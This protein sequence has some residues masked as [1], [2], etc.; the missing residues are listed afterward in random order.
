MPQVEVNQ[1]CRD[2]APPLAAGEPGALVAQQL[3]RALPACGQCDEAEAE[4]TE[5]ESP[6]AVAIERRE[7]GAH[8]H[9]SR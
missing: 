8:V 9:G 3:T 6:A 2:G 4:G 7:Y 1:V 5:C